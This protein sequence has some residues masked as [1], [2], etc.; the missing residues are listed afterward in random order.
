MLTFNCLQKRESERGK[1]RM[2]GALQFC[3]HVVCLC[4]TISAH[5]TQEKPLALT[6]INVND[7]PDGQTDRRGE[8]AT[9]RQTDVR[10]KGGKRDG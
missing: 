10:L 4:T 2:G 7:S 1:G 9:E 8:R 3:R 6:V 5:K